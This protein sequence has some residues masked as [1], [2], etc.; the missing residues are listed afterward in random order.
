MPV[1]PGEVGMFTIDF[2]LP[3]DP[4]EMPPEGERRAAVR[5][6]C[7]GHGPDRLVVRAGTESRWARPC[8]ISVGGIGLLLA[9][10]VAPGTRLTIQMRGQQAALSPGLEAVVVYA[11][12]LEHGIWRVG[13]AFDHPLSDRELEQ[14]L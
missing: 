9:Q 14:F 4:V 2:S 7:S 3:E 12:P 1:A 5:H 13:C 6:P 10:P 11:R 8:D